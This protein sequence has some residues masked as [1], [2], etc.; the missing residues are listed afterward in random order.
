MAVPYTFGSAT[1]SI[2]LSQLDSNFATTI[3]LGN[4]AIQLGNTVTTLNNMTLGNVTISSGTS[5]IQTNVANATGVLLEANGGT[6]TTTGYYGFK[7]RII[8]GA[9]VIS[10]RNGTSTVTPADGDY[11]L[12][13]YL[14]KVSQSSKLTVAQSTTAPSGFSN[15]YKVT[16]SAA[17]TVGTSDY[18]AVGQYIEGFNVADLNWGSANAKTVT[19]SFQVYSSLTGTFGGVLQNNTRD[20]GYPFT[21]T[22]SS[23]N[24]WT[25]ISVTIAGDTSGTWVNDSG[26]GIRIV[27]GL[28][29]GSTYT[30]TATG[31]WQATG[32][33][34]GA[35]G[36]VNVVST[37]GATFYI[38]G[39]QL[40]KGSTATSFDY[41]P[42]GTELQLCQR[43]YQALNV[44]SD[45]APRSTTNGQLR[46]CV[47]FPVQ[48][49]TAPTATVYFNTSSGASADITYVNSLH[50][51][52]NTNATN[53]VYN[54]S[55]PSVLVSS[56]L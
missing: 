9:M 33:L 15:S 24:T 29:V 44:T 7:N 22:I 21:Y 28:G 25:S 50:C 27:W 51:V 36:C 41:R 42:Y 48:M 4:T 35:S 12:D 1:T 14:V 3:T 16:S 53:Y 45:L 2:P 31:A 30:A 10:Q 18:F 34:F 37:N 56:E 55:G 52:D 13:R 5:N 19:L 54:A 46:G 40:E 23:A 11:T 20:R 32:V 39:V 26:L 17:T 38:T 6:G 43:Y 47:Y 49:R 8:N